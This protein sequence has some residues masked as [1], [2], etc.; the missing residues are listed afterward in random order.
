MAFDFLPWQTVTNVS[1]FSQSILRVMSLCESNMRRIRE[2][3]MREV[4]IMSR[5]CNALPCDENHCAFM[6][7]SRHIYL[8]TH[9]NESC[10][11]A[12]MR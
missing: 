3:N 11:V 9:I 5:C 8:G 1:T 12:A 10:H 6:N 4:R 2:S 7:A